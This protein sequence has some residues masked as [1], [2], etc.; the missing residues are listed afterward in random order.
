VAPWTDYSV[1]AVSG[2]FIV[3]YDKDS[4]PGI[5]NA[6]F[7]FVKSPVYPAVNDQNHVAFLALVEPTPGTVGVTPS[8]NMG[9]WAEVGG[10]N[11]LIARTGTAAPGTSGIFTSFQAPVFNNNDEVAFYG[12][13]ETGGIKASNRGGIWATNSGTLD[14]VAQVN[15]PAPAPNGDPTEAVFAGFPQ[16]VLP[17]QGGVV[18]VGTLNSGT[19]FN[20]KTGAPAVPGPGGITASNNQG[21]WA[22][23]SNGVL[24]RIICTGQTQQIDGIAK[25]VAAI[26][27]FKGPANSVGQSRNFNVGGDLTFTVT[28]TDGSTAIEQLVF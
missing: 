7:N 13:F 6:R 9:I 20:T 18:F 8:N 23:D 28:F 16:L 21:V 19:P 15:S 14:L 22:V 3:A 17:D 26:G 4:A 1:Q 11:S 2:L 27:I 25:T 10:I 12:T 5:D 24:K